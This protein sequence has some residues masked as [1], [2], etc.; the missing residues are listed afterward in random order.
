LDTH[1]KLT[2][3]QEC[4]AETVA[5]KF[6]EKWGCDPALTFYYRRHY[7]HSFNTSH[8]ERGYLGGRYVFRL[9]GLKASGS[10]AVGA[11]YPFAVVATSIHQVFCLGDYIRGGVVGHWVLDDFWLL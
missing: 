11:T 7:A 1:P 9:H 4:T 5:R 6:F 8:F 3:T 10:N 2:D